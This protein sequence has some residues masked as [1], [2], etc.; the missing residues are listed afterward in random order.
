[1]FDDVLLSIIAEFLDYASY[2]A[3]RLAIHDIGNRILNPSYRDIPVHRMEE[4]A[5]CRTFTMVNIW[6]FV[7]VVI[8][9]KIYF[10]KV[11]KCIS[12]HDCD[13]SMTLLK[14]ID[15]IFDRL[16]KKD[17]IEWFLVNCRQRDI[18][19]HIKDRE[20]LCLAPLSIVARN[21]DCSHLYDIYPKASTDEIGMHILMNADI[22]IHKNRIVDKQLDRYNVDKKYPLTFK[23]MVNMVL[24]RKY[25]KFFTG[26]YCNVEAAIIHHL[27]MTS[28]CTL[29]ADGTVSFTRKDNIVAIYHLLTSL[30]PSSG[31]DI[32]HE[33]AALL[34]LYRSGD[35]RVDY[36]KSAIYRYAMMIPDDEMKLITAMI[37]GII[38]DN[39]MEQADKII[40]H[41]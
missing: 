32:Y 28:G 22:Q 11:S 34:M 29:C 23:A 9:R 6:E 41:Q 31:M 18:Y 36:W 13:V 2:P 12:I 21:I 39:F 5:S 3:L 37:I 16:I 7:G 4:Y 8:S 1:M 24:S 30:T 26:R 38:N 14:T 33:Y 19:H 40:N 20:I 25:T 10:G 35:I 27:H 17:P 15:S